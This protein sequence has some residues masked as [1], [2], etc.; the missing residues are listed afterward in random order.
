MKPS[1]TVLD[2]GCGTGYLLQQM[3][4]QQEI[5]GYGIDI[6]PNM[7][8]E[9]RKKCPEMDILVSP[10]EKTPFDNNEFDVITACMAYHH[11]SDK[12]KFAEEASRILKRGGYVYIADPRFP[13]LVRKPINGILKL[14]RIT[15]KFFTAKEITANF[16]RFGFELDCVNRKGIVQVIKLKKAE[17]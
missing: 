1:Y 13:Y 6:E 17:L 9:A 2:V 12:E 4:K 10:C 15:G 11:F 14:F 16:N 7:I 8:E 3:S 5:E